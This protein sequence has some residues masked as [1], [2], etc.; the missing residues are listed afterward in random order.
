[1]IKRVHYRD[2]DVD[3]EFILGFAKLDEV[4]AAQPEFVPGRMYDNLCLVG[5]AVIKRG[6]THGN[7]KGRRDLAEKHFPEMKIERLRRDEIVNKIGLAL[8]SRV[9]VEPD[10]QGCGIGRV[11][12]QECRKQAASL[13]PGSRYVEVMTSQ[14]LHDAQ[15]LVKKENTERDFLQAAGFRLVPIFTKARKPHDGRDRCLYYWAPVL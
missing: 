10:L 13:V 11:L 14:R 9:A 15:R 4:K 3:G 2:G 12:A 8:I 6:I 5:T 1:M 7:P